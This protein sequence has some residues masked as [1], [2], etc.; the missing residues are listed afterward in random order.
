MLPNDRRYSKE[1]EWIRPESG[2]GV[3]GLTKF[4]VDELGDIVYVELPAVGATVAQFKAFG[5]VESVKAVSDLFAPASGE[6][7]AVNEALRTSPELM[8]SDPYDA[9][10]LCR[11]RLTDAA[12]LDALLD[13]AAYGE[14]TGTE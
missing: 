7:I 10:W 3:V 14:L 2:E 9:G 1:H 11:I 13:A 8:N 5:V 12:E 4:A 6:V